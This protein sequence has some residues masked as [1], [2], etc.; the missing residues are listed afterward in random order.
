MAL[1]PVRVSPATPTGQDAN[2]RLRGLTASRFNRGN[3]DGLAGSRA[4]SAWSASRS[5]VRTQ[6]G[7]HTAV[8][9]GCLYRAWDPRGAVDISRAD[10]AELGNRDLMPPIR[11]T[12]LMEQ[13]LGHVAHDQ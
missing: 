5:H 4:E 9:A 6:R 7:V 13:V 12:F 1:H 11:A 8:L 3:V 10:A 2:P